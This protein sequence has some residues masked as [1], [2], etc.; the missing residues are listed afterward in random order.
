M[1]KMPPKRKA[2]S[3]AKG[4][5]GLETSLEE[6]PSTKE[7]KHEIATIKSEFKSYPI[8]KTNRLIEPGPV[9]LVSTGAVSNSTHNLMT[10]GFH[11]MLQHTSPT[12]ISVCIGPWDHSFK[13]LS[14]TKEC[15]LAIPEVSIAEKV[16]DI[17]NCSGDQVDKWTDFGLDP[18]EAGK[19]SAPLVGGSG[20]IANVECVV[21]DDAMV[22][23][24]NMWV[25][26][27]VK[28]WVRV[29]AGSD[30]LSDGMKMFH[31]RGDGRF[32]VGGDILDLRERM[33]MWTEFQD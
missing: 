4:K 26:R 32:A 22:D 11:M 17:G 25:L 5:T 7:P 27:V 15:V 8:S 6:E 1:T 10:I 21:A 18:L 24:Y 28:S 3:S 13:A 30:G 12:L 31:H 33:V 29:D 16:V 23:K 2:T 14:E 9:L 19:I 20:I